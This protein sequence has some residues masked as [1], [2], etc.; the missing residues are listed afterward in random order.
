MALLGFPSEIAAERD[1]MVTSVGRRAV[2]LDRDGVINANIV[3]NQRPYAPT[4]LEDFRFLPGVETAVRRLKEAG[5]LVVV[6]TNQPDV[7]S[8][9]TPLETVETMHAKIRKTLPVDEIEV[10]VHLDSDGCACRKPKPGLLLQAAAKHHIDTARSWMVGDRWRDVDAGR[11]AG[12]ATI[13]I[14]YGFIQEQPVRAEKIVRSLAEATEYI[15]EIEC[16]GNRPMTEPKV[17]RLKIKIFADGADLKGIG[18][19]AADP[20]I[21]GFTTNPTLMRAAGVND[22][23]AFALDV[24]KIVSDRPVSFEVFADDL[25]AMQDQAL[26]IAS[27]GSNVYVKIPVTTTKGE[28]AGPIIRTLSSRGVKLNVTAIMGLDQVRQVGEALAPATSAIV[29]V[30]AGRIADTG[31][32]P[33]PHMGEALRILASRPK[34]ELL[35]ASPRELL[36]IF[37]A[38]SI[39]CHII[40][41]TG[42]LLNKL[43][44]V[45]KDLDEYSRETVTMFFRDATSAGYSISLP[46]HDRVPTKAAL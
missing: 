43:S 17:D 26:E 32:D 14:D 34:A 10:C 7:S 40:T 21:K 42:D 38:D 5:F 1:E 37:H 2:F 9:V 22:Y 31:R 36:N 25:A 8:G 44:L 11:A 18:K 6:V 27:W 4:K 28:F 35:W 16:R 23:K 12:C 39:G 46:S 3:R 15:L 13:F 20:R 41:V 30:F 33:V 45:G 24:L 19:F 29:S